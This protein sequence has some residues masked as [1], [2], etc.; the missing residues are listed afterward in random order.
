MFTRAPATTLWPF[1]PTFPPHAMRLLYVMPCR[2]MPQTRHICLSIW[3][4][5]T[6]FSCPS[7]T[8]TA[9]MPLFYIHGRYT[10]MDYP[11][12]RQFDQDGVTLGDQ[13]TFNCDKRSCTIAL[14]EL[15]A[16]SSG[17]YRCEISGDAPEFKLASRTANMTVGGKC[18]C[19]AHV[20]CTYEY[21]V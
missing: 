9:H 21:V 11:N 5:F 18:L 2:A 1:V 6:I 10:P 3:I 8:H 17:A 4:I 7:I 12:F 15:S 16:K 13:R 19:T 20:Q 14:R